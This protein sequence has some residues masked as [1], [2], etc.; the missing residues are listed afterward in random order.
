MRLSK[1]PSERGLPAKPGGGEPKFYPVPPAAP[2]RADAE[3]GPYTA[4]SHMVELHTLLHVCIHL[5]GKRAQCAQMAPYPAA[6]EAAAG[7]GGRKT[8]KIPGRAGGII[9]KM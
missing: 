3:A 7:P 5:M 2:P 4:P 6:F 1:A 8:P 9:P